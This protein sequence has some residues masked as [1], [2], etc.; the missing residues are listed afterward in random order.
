MK[1]ICLAILTISII[2]FGSQE[3]F[4]QTTDSTSSSSAFCG[5]LQFQLT[6]GVGIYYIGELS[7]SSY[8]RVGADLSLNR[9]DQSG[10][11]SSLSSS[12]TTLSQP[13]QSTNSYQISLSALYIQKLAE[14]KKTFL[15]CGVGPMVTYSW[16]RGTSSYPSTDYYQ[17]TTESEKYSS[18]YTSRI[19]GIGPMAIFGVRTRLANQVGAS[20]EIGISAVYQWNTQSGSSS[21]TYIGYGTTSTSNNSDISHLNGWAVSLANVRVGVVFEL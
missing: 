18:E 6:G 10:S 9:S 14:Y 16:Q 19:S 20:A 21:S 8:Y 1:A 4:S 2:T 17:G 15:Y 5:A 11:E 7:Q 3:T 13:K 12:D